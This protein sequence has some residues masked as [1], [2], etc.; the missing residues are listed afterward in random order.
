METPDFQ[1][2]SHFVGTELPAKLRDPAFRYQVVHRFARTDENK[3]L[4]TRMRPPLQAL[5]CY[6]TV[7]NPKLRAESTDATE[8]LLCIL[9]ATILI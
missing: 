4:I 3:P 7:L 2:A 6:A 5:G 8:P 9:L 1:A